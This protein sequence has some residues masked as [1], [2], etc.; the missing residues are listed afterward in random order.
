LESSP[1]SL[2]VIFFS[3]LVFMVR[4]CYPNYRSWECHLFY[5]IQNEFEYDSQYIFF[6]CSVKLTDKAIWHCVSSVG[7]FLT[8]VSI[9]LLLIGL[10]IFS[11]F[12]LTLF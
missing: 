8:I 4:F 12:F 6:A 3:F 5:Y 11:N 1:L 7:R 2:P 9:Y 10:F